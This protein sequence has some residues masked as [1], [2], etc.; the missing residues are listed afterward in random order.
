SELARIWYRENITMIFVTQDVDEAIY[1]GDRVG[2]V[3]PH[4]GR[5]SAQFAVEIERPRQRTDP[6]FNN[7]KARIL[8]ALEPL[9]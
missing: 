3:A 4:Q 2:V 5:I 1:L 7:L 6:A 8:G 9:T